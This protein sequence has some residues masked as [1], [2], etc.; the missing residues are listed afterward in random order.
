MLGQRKSE[1][2]SAIVMDT[3]EPENPDPLLRPFK[4][5]GLLLRNRI[6]STSHVISYAVDGMPSERYQRYHEEKAKGGIGLTMFGG[7]SNVSPDSPSTRNQI[8]VGD[9]AI[10][11]WFERFS[12]RIHAHGC[13][14][15]CQLTHMG[16]RTVWH[17]GE[18]LPIIAPS[19]V[20]ERTHRCTPKEMD[21]ADIE[22]VVKAFGAAARRCRQGGIDGCEI[23]AHA[24]LIEQFWSP[25]VNR[26][27][28]RFGGSFANRMRFGLMVLE[29]VRR[30][31]GDDFV[32]GVRMTMSEGHEGG[33]TRDD[34]IRIAKTL[35]ES[36]LVD[37][38]NL[39]YGRVDTELGLAQM[40]PGMAMAAAPYLPLVADFRRELHLA[41]VHACRITD[42]ATARRA[43]GEGLVD[44]VGMM[45]AHMADPYIV[46]KIAAGEEHRIRPCVG[47]TYCTTHRV[48]IH[49]PATG[50]EA[51][52]PH[53]IAA[54]P[55]PRRKVVVV[56]GGP[57][58]LEAARVSAARGHDVVLYEGAERLGGQIVLAA[59]AGWRAEL[60]G[61]ARWLIQEVELARV[62]IHLGALAD[63]ATVIDERPDV[64]IAA[65]GG[66]PDLG[67]LEGGEHCTS[68]WDVLAGRSPVA[69]EVLLF[70]GTGQHQG[71]SCAEYLAEHAARIELVTP[72]HM[73]AFDTGVLDRPFY[74]KHFCQKGIAITTDHDLTSVRPTN[75][76]LC[77]T[78]RNELTGELS[79][80][81]V[82][83]VV[84]ESGTV[85]ADELYHELR[86]LSVN[87]GVTDIDALLQG[88]A[89]AAE[90][91]VGGGFQLFRVG[92]AVS[93]RDIHCAI[94]DALR[95]CKDL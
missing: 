93:G 46:N 51:T 37:F 87:D 11:P 5:K 3:L 58:G 45:R 69:P 17:G 68:A 16:R 53:R 55:G 32:L 47:A 57:A 43:V 29:E 27:T 20:R 72:D 67:W 86:P 54:S 61:V 36:G 33:L 26:R 13:A 56:G 1:T 30:Q 78:L 35:E 75:G 71:A 38:L 88:R 41:L 31:A 14:L 24:H 7:S 44:L 15:M 23:A 64:V 39:N 48:C 19:G 65:T 40:M 82:D 77:A 62:R 79:E 22:R 95:L 66:R 89:Q 91:N 42:A 80:R 28:D 6:V 85:P 81:A 9:D 21:L 2:R 34:C 73:A 8:Y 25:A 83:Q 84:V 12:E 74:L 4:L 59:S 10:I 60:I 50:R 63:R 52:L 90:R 18:W 76:R 49:N 94:L 92:D 70:D